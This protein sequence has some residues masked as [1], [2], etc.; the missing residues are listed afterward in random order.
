MSVF[1]AALAAWMTSVAHSAELPLSVQHDIEYVRELCR[2]TGERFRFDKDYLKQ[3]DF[4]ADGRI[5]YVI[6]ARGFDCDN[7]TGRLYS[8]HGG[9]LL[10][11][12]LSQPDG[13]WKQVF[14]SYAREHDIRDVYGEPP[15][16]DVWVRAEIGYQTMFQRYQWDGEDFIVIEQESGVEVPKQLWKRFD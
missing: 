16:F 9:W 15:Y 2:A 5:D 7:L 8:A 1:K 14:N 13:T 4:N 10:Y 12:H 11:V 6:D 3:A